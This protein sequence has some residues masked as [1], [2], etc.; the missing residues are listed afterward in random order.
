VNLVMMNESLLGY[1]LLEQKLEDQDLTI[2]QNYGERNGF[3]SSF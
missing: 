2:I 3:V 1:L